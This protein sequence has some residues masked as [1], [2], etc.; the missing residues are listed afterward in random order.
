MWQRQPVICVLG[1]RMLGK[2]GNIPTRRWEETEFCL[3]ASRGLLRTYSIAPGIYA[4]YHYENP[5]RFHA[6]TLPRTI[7]L[8]EGDKSVLQIHL[9]SIDD[10]PPAD[11]KLFEPTPAM[12]PQQFSSVLAGAFR[13]PMFGGTAPIET[14][15][16]IQPVIVHASVSPDGSVQEAE[17]LQPSDPALSAAA[18]ALVKNRHVSL[19]DRGWTGFGEVFVNVRF[20]PPNTDAGK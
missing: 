7:S 9:E 13:M 11:P 2:D 15:G 4:V 18:L 16:F 1:S 20:M 17:T 6:S 3:D 14:H 19:P 8:Y 10:A 5:L 12:T